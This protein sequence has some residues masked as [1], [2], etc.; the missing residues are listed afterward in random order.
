VRQHEPST[1]AV[2]ARAR[3]SRWRSPCAAGP[4]RS[5]PLCEEHR[6]GFRGVGHRRSRPRR[7]RSA[8]ST[9]VTGTQPIR[10]TVQICE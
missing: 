7:N 8:I 1:T 9:V 2:P 5:A 6:R 4:E 10:A 3:T